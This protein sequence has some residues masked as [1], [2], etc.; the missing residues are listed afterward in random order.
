[1]FNPD[2]EALIN[3]PLTKKSQ[4][5]QVQEQGRQPP[6]LDDVSV[7]LMNLPSVMSFSSPL[8]A[9]LLKTSKKN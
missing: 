9:P 7:S 4:G 5:L 2:Q 3:A 6:S 1:M 8:H